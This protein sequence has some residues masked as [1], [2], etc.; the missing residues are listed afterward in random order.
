MWRAIKQ[1]EEDAARAMD[2]YQARK[3]AFEARVTAAGVCDVCKQRPPTVCGNY[4]VPVFCDPCDR[5]LGAL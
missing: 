3:R 4:R 1:L 2:A 5:L